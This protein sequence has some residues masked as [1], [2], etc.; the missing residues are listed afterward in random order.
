MVCLTEGGRILV[1]GKYFFLAINQIFTGI[2]KDKD[3][4]RKKRTERSEDEY[5]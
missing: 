5:P 1:L 3:N 2:K 4:S